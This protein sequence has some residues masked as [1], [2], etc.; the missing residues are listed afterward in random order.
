[1]AVTPLA[2]RHEAHGVLEATDSVLLSFLESGR[3][4]SQVAE[5]GTRVTRGEVM[6]R[7]EGRA[8]THA[9]RGAE[10]GARE[11]EAALEEAE[12]DQARAQELA[13]RGAVA[14]EA[15]EHAETRVE[16]ALATVSAARTQVRDARRRD[17]E[18]TLRAPFE[19]VVTDVMVEASELVEAGQPVFRLVG[20]GG[21]EVVVRVPR[22]LVDEL[23]VGARVEVRAS[24]VE[25]GDPL[26][27]RTVEGRIASIARE[28][29]ALGGMHPVRVA[30]TSTEGIAAGLGVVVVFRGAERPMVT[31]PLA[32]V[33]APSGTHPYVWHAV[34]GRAERATVRLGPLLDERLVVR[35]G[36][37]RGDRVVVE[38]YSRLL[39]GDPLAVR[40][41]P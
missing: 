8:I 11:A 36:L 25:A 10:A 37:T 14:A 33:Q 18:T 19:G 6:A 28:A 26:A 30:V 41:S 15:V 22:A 21:L 16:R 7:L 40:D 1:M 23:R 4:E 39:P 32:A 35:E 31:V 5:V 34:D 3:V 24:G 38:G 2:P 13:G 27:E 20:A 17:D 9:L 12:R 29:S